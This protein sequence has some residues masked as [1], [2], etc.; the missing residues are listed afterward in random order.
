MS[1]KKITIVVPTDFSKVAESA[2]EHAIGLCNSLGN[3]EIILLHILGKEKEKEEAEIKL[4]KIAE[5]LSKS[6]G[7]KIG[8]KTRVGNIFEDI[9]AAAQKLKAKLIIMGT[10]GVKGM[11]Y[12]TGS[13]AVKVIT[14]S[15]VPF[16]VVQERGFRQGYNNIV[17]P[18][19]LSKDTKQ[20]LDFA[21]NIAKVFNSK[22]HIV[23]P[24]ETDEFLSSAIRNN[25]ALV[26]SELTN[27][28]LDFDAK[29][30]EG[31]FVK[32]FL[33]YAASQDADL[34]AIVNSQEVGL[35]EIL[36]GTDERQIITNEAKIPTM[37][38]NPVKTSIESSVLFG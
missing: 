27:N 37:I 22:I 15:T 31:S 29:E 28:N 35:P 7:V 23:Y 30:V 13:Y 14:H 20:K 16:I 17:L 18:F 8:Y 10:H 2:T 33:N 1:K 36:A 38:I 4:Q 25:I 24:K 6:S 34:I 9:G 3:A 21:I 12:I 19:D 26:K 32:Q 5:K 11:Q